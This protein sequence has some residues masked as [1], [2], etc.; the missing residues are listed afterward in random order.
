MS[1]NG[2]GFGA[3][4]EPPSASPERRQAAIDR[5]LDRFDQKQRRRSQG[6]PGLLRLIRRTTSLVLPT[7]RSFAMSHAIPRAIPRL[8][9]GARYLV[10]ASLAVLVV[11]SAVLV[12]LEQSPFVPSAV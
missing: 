9:P 8:M 2:D 6:F 4:P 3:F 7:R 5:A 11:G 1:R 12:S 10:A